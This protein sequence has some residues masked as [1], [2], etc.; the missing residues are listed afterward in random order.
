[1]RWFISRFPY[2]WELLLFLLSGMVRYYNNLDPAAIVF[3]EVH[4]GGFVEGYHTGHYFFDIHPPLGKLS[5]L[6]LGYLFGYDPS[7]CEYKN[8]SDVYPPG[9][10]FYILR[11]I[12]GGWG[13]PAC[14]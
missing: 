8:I 5:L 4:F 12:A 2:P 3:D 10:K 7:A 6:W 11:R 9:C 14:V 1:M 13:A